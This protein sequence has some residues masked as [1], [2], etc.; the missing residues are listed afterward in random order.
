[1]GVYVDMDIKEMV[2]FRHEK[3]KNPQF[4]TRFRGVPSECKFMICHPKHGVTATFEPAPTVQVQD[5]VIGI[6]N[7]ATVPLAKFEC[8]F[9]TKA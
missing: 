6:L 4:A 5:A 8:K 2:I 3:G 1:M 9:E 7:P